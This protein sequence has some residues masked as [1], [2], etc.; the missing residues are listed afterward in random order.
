M[1]IP[2][3]KADPA[4]ATQAEITDLLQILV[5]RKTI[6]RDQAERVRRYARANSTPVMQTIVQLGIASEIQITE[7]AAAFAGLRFVRINPLELDLDVVTSALS[8]PFARKHGLVALSKT[9]GK[10]VVAVHDPFAPFP[11]ED[12]KRVTGIL[13]IERVV[14]TYTEIT[15]IHKSFYE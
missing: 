14:S 7:A 8:G 3:R 10:L 11:A 9:D 4:T 1:A 2:P 12:I 6:T 15:A 5:F 13:D